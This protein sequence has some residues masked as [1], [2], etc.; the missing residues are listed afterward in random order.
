MSTLNKNDEVIIPAPYWVSYPDMVILSEGKP[1]IVETEMQNGFKINSNQLERSISD[2]TKWFILNSP[3][4][5]LAM[6]M[7]KIVIRISQIL[8]KIPCKYFV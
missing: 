3:E 7:K 4:I 6:Y 1:I 5:R 2:K 8:L